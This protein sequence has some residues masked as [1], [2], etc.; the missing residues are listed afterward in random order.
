MNN[1]G[2]FK[3]LQPLNLLLHL[4]KSHDSAHLEVFSNSVSWSFEFNQG[5][6]VYASNSVEPFDRLERHLRRLQKNMPQINSE[7]RAQLR[8]M[9][10]PDSRSQLITLP[11]YQAVCWLVSQKYLSVQQAAEVIEEL[12]KEVLE[13]F[14]LIKIGNYQFGSRLQKLPV[15][16]NLNVETV[17]KYCQ[18]RL[19]T[20]QSLAPEI[21]SPFQRPYP[22][23]QTQRMNLPGVEENLTYW[24]KGFSLRHLA[25]ITNQD[26][27]KLAQS[28]YPYIRKGNLALHEPDPPFDKLPKTF[29]QASV[30][31]SYLGDI[32]SK[33]NIPTS[34]PLESQPIVPVSD[35]TDNQQVVETAPSPLP[36]IAQSPPVINKP[37]PSASN[38]KVYKIVSVDDSD[39]ILREIKRFLEDEIFSVVTVNNPVKALLPIIRHKPDLILLDVNMSGIDGY[40]LCR[41]LRN[42]SMFKS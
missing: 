7:I 14:L 13:S 1:L 34:L 33:K 39:M 16:A 12:V 10:E 27:L 29:E 23:F 20:W 31:T 41:L 32:V 4:S 21:T 28:L 22:V 8:L 37:T 35:T 40:E 9:F 5:N 26:E 15:L 30:S 17:V 2:T 11:D 36:Q 25:V 24:M 3:K 42:N 18:Y 6:I 38:H 19:E